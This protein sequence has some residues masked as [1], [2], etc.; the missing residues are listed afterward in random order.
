MSSRAHPR[1]LVLGL[2]LH[3][4]ELAQAAKPHIED[5]FGLRSVSLNA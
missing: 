5:R 2:D 4:F 1:V 3:L